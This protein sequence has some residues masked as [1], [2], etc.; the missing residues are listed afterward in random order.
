[1]SLH[2]SFTERKGY[3]LFKVF[4]GEFTEA[5]SK[6]LS[7]PI[8]ESECA[9]NY[10]YSSDSDLEGDDDAIK[11]GATLKKTV[12]LKDHRRGAVIEI[13]DIAFI[14]CVFSYVYCH[15]ADDLSD[16]RPFYSICI[17][18]PSTLHHMDQKETASQRVPRPFSRRRTQYL[19]HHQSQ[20]IVSQIRSVLEIGLESAGVMLPSV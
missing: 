20:S 2:T 6:D 18:V 3:N 8:D 17:P 12:A 16:F 4:S 19:D 15:V 10:G 1:M 11:E 5:K 14:T 7:E 9:E 13:K